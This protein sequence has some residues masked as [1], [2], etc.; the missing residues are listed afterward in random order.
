MA[1][2]AWGFSSLILLILARP[3]TKLLQ[4]LLQSGAVD[5]IN[6]SRSA[7]V[8]S[9]GTSYLGLSLRLSPLAFL[10]S[11]VL[12]LVIAALSSLIPARGISRINPGTG[13]RFRGGVRSGF[14]ALKLDLWGSLTVA[15]C[16]LF[17]LLPL[18]ELSLDSAQP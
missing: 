14:D 5:I 6:Q 7:S 1:V 15:L 12:L 9:T 2:A 16:L 13:I 4:A 17:A 3:W 8:A 11:L 10:A 18:S